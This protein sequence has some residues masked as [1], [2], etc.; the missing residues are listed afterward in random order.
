MHESLHHEAGKLG[1]KVL[2]VCPGLFR[3]AFT[4]RL[5]F[6]R[7]YAGGLG[8]SEPYKGTPLEMMVSLSKGL[9]SSPQGTIGDPD[10]AANE[11]LKAVVEGHDY[12]RMIL[13]KDCIR[14]MED[15]ISEYNRDLEATRVIGSAVEVD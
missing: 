3:T 6:P 14:A 5:I 10:K 2:I 9:S 4:S 15:K 8:F 12:L 13:G 1:I 7:Q 11:I